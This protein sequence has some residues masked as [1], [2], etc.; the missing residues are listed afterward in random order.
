MM[1]YLTL[2]AAVALLLLNGFFVAA[3]FA[4]VKVRETRLR[5]LQEQGSRRAGLAHEMV[6]H[7]DAYLSA[8]QLGITLA[9][10]GLGWV[11]EAAVADRIAPLLEGIG[12][13]SGAAVHGIAG[14]IAFMIVTAAH[15]VIGEL[16]PKSIAIQRSEEVTLW[17]ALPMRLFYRL[18]YPALF[19]LN[20]SANLVLRVIGLPPPSE[21]GESLTSEEL[22]MVLASSA[23][24]GKLTD[25]ELELL[26]NVFSFAS[27]QVREVM[28]PR[29]DVYWLDARLPFSANMETIAES[30]H[31]R[32]PLCDGDLDQVLGLI[33]I[34]DI[35]M[36]IESGETQPNLMAIRHPVVAVPEGVSLQQALRD[37]RRRRVQ[38]ALVVDEYGSIAGAVTIEDLIEEIVGEIEDEFDEPQPE[39]EIRDD[40]K[41]IVSGRTAI[42]DVNE[43]FDLRLGGETY[44]TMAGLVLEHLGRTAV[45]GDVVEV[46]GARVTVLAVEGLRITRILVE[47]IRPESIEERDR[48]YEE[49][50]E[51]ERRR[52]ADEDLGFVGPPTSENGDTAAGPLNGRPSPGEDDDPRRLGPEAPAVAG[53]PP[54]V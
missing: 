2:L 3:E 15:I 9:S 44:V 4:I 35:F 1:Q 46:P 31:T 43:A 32:F 19:V 6:V 37:L 24:G 29:A 48:L 17:V 50:E 36:R 7:L 20:R 26:D 39:M 23:K 13:V 53:G 51:R 12:V 38:L 33:H 54:K 16:A 40:G 27:R 45:E 21:S 5:E 28:V 30:G 25:A 18:S 41:V 49:Q 14:A 22:R 52:E 34:K 10:L 11:S 47:L 8:T 42:A